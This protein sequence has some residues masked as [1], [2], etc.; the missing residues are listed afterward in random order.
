VA[1]TRRTGRTRFTVLL[2]VLTAVTLLTLDGRQFGPIDSARSAV[3]SVL[4]PVGDA[5]S[6]AFEPVTNAWQAAFDQGDLERRN[7]ELQEEIERLQGE[8][9]AGEVSR[10]QLQDL[11]ENEGINFTGDLPRVHARV[12]AGSVSSFGSTLDLDKG[13][14]DGIA[15]GMA[16][17]TGKGLV[18][19]VVQV[20]SDRCTVEL[21]TSGNYQVGVTAIGTTAVGIVQGTGSPTLLRGTNFDVD[22][23]VEVGDI[24]VTGG[25]RA[26][27]FPPDLPVGTIATVQTDDAARQT[28]VDVTMFART[29]DL[30]YADVVIW[31]P[32]EVG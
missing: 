16:V 7:E 32:E 6:S 24:V 5:A 13:S 19:K 17:V 26:S 31:Q 15:E 23:T 4:S 3:L 18:G 29:T 1:V 22:Q 20:S 12:V 27:S 11:L 14:S 28:T 25:T 2:L 9:T 21:I 8:V 30:T 10:Q